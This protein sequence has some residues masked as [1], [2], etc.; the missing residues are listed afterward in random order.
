M[1]RTDRT[2]DLRRRRSVIGVGTA[3][4]AAFAAALI[5][6]GMAPAAGADPAAI[7]STDLDPFGDLYGNAGVNT[8]TTQADTM[9]ASLSPTLANTLDGHVDAFLTSG[10]A[11]LS[12]LLFSVD[13]SAF[14]GNPATGG[15]PD[16]A[17]GDLAFT[18]DYLGLGKVVTPLEGLL[19]GGGADAASAAAAAPT[20][21]TEGNPFEDLFGATGFNAWTVGV[22]QELMSVA[23]ALANQL[24]I[25]VDAFNALPDSDPIS[26]LVAALDPSAFTAAGVPANAIGDLAVGIDWGLVSSGLGTTLDPIIDNLLS[27]VLPNLF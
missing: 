11:P 14:T 21:A 15:L 10:S 8:W 16:N 25:S 3:T 26:D 1:S 7:T 2:S 6:I 24:D 19:G 23:P 5:S 17:V 4:G 18:L 20:L 13:P 9:L 22:D 27:G 12:D